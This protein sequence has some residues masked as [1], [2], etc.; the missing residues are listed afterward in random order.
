[1]NARLLAHPPLDRRPLHGTG[2][3]TD[4]DTAIA[5]SIAAGWRAAMNDRQIKTVLGAVAVLALLVLL[6]ESEL[7]M[8]G[9]ITDRTLGVLAGL[10]WGLLNIDIGL[11]LSDVVQADGADENDRQRKG[12]G[13]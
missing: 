10:I 1:M 2:T 5:T 12:K 11:K 4:T 6:V 8:P 9:P 13:E 7:A 3:G